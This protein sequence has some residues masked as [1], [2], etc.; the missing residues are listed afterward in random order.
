M[1]L[2]TLTAISTIAAAVGTI[3][4]AIFVAV[5]AWYSKQSANAAKGAVEEAQKAR[6]ME[7]TP[8]LI[9][10]KNFLD[11][12]FEWPHQASLNGEAVFLSRKHWQDKDLQAPTFSLKNC[13][14]NPALEITIVFELE[15]PN[16]E[17]RLPPKYEV[18]G[19]SL[20]DMGGM[21]SQ[22]HVTTLMY[23]KPGGGCGLPLYHKETVDIP[24]CAPDQTRVVD[25]P[26]GL[27]NTL[28]LRGLQL[29]GVRSEGVN[30]DITLVARISC[31][32]MDATKCETQYRWKVIPFSYGQ[33]N[34]VVVYG[35][36]FELPMYPKPTGPRVG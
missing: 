6:R 11:F 22:H 1:K 24:S 26:Q 29:G 35:H 16:G 2:E 5:S 19:L 4:A 32:A 20:R 3:A 12:H 27:L 15:D 9:L 28:F 18:L 25:F 36:C 14:Q 23:S 30:Q 13:G 17:L 10:E 7:L 33:V 34:P 21:S 8:K 31:Y